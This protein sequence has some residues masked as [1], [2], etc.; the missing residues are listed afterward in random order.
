MSSAVPIVFVAVLL[1]APDEAE[2]VSVHTILREAFTAADAAPDRASLLPALAAMMVRSGHADE[3]LN[4]AEG[5]EDDDLGISVIRA[6]GFAQARI[7]DFAGAIRTA[8]RLSTR[9]ARQVIT[10][11]A[12]TQ[13]WV[14]DVAGAKHIV[15]VDFKDASTLEINGVNKMIALAQ[16][17][18]GD[19]AGAAA[20]F[21]AIPNLKEKARG[22]RP[23]ALACLKAGDLDGALDQAEESRRLAVEYMRGQPGTKTPQILTPNWFR[24]GILGKISRELASKG[25]FVGARR[26]AARIASDDSR[27][28]A[29]AKLAALAARAGEK[30]M[31]NAL[32]EDALAQ[33]KPE[34]YSGFELVDIASAETVLGQVEKGR[35]RFLE[36]LSKAGPFESNEALVPRDQALAGDYEG[37]LNTANA[38]SSLSARQLAI[39]YISGV[40]AKVGEFRNAV[41]LAESLRSTNDRVIALC[42]V[43]SAQAEKGD[44]HGAN[45][46]VLRAMSVGGRLTG[47]TL[48]TVASLAAELGGPSRAL[49]W[50]NT[51]SSS[52]DKARALLGVAEGLLP[53][54][55]PGPNPQGENP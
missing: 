47:E 31:A 4:L 13:A 27:V 36:A 10:L 1:V 52:A 35:K 54:V 18:T 21:Q 39:Q 11:V 16:E 29:F 12:A 14:G 41:E 17:Q 37:A 6:T 5:H 43:S 9:D 34:N 48:R 23:A 38:T 25:D 20:T 42:A 8:R 51:R 28:G 19:F 40:M 53:K 49:A 3:A 26:A 22:C 24:D 45:S 15:E 55:L 2:D 50:V 30:K 33:A 7:H 46:T 44:R 32:L